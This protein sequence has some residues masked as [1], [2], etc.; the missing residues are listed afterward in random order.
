[1]VDLSRDGGLATAP[2]QVPGRS[3][4]SI[5]RSQQM[6]GG[7]QAFNR[8]REKMIDF[9]SYPCSVFFFFFRFDPWTRALPWVACPFSY[10]NFHFL[11][12]HAFFSRRSF[13]PCLVINPHCLNPAL[14]RCRLC[15]VSN[16]FQF[17]LN[18]SSISEFRILILM[19][20]NIS[21]VL[22][23]GAS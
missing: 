5:L 11:P 21:G 1:M 7:S 6:S 2:C 8:L 3:S 9:S 10:S 19:D 20:Q 15:S 12:E 14:C 22:N 23:S 17:H 18:T 16:C 4:F 13:R